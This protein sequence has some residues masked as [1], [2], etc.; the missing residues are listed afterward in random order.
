MNLLTIR[1]LVVFF[2]LVFDFVYV[3]L[4]RNYYEGHV[5]KIQNKGY[6]T[7]TGVYISAILAYVF[8]ALGWWILVAERLNKQTTIYELLRITLPY[9][10]VIFGVFNTTLY[11]MFDAW[12]ARIAIRDT[13]WGISSITFTSLLYL[14]LVKSL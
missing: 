2:Y 6:S 11:V 10:L 7:K 5:R 9:S 14:Y 8:L 13:V 4:S 3:F 12:D 1:W